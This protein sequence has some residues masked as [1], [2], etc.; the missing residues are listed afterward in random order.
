MKRQV[1]IYL[2]FIS[3]ILILFIS[4]KFYKH[5]SDYIRILKIELLGDVA[6]NRSL[7]ELKVNF[8]PQLLLNFKKNN[9]IC[10]FTPTW[11]FRPSHAVPTYPIPVVGDVDKN[12]NPEIYIGSYSKE[13]TALDGRSHN[14]LWQWKLPFG[15]I[16]GR[17]M[18]LSDLDGDGHEELLV[19]S[20]TTLPIR[21][22]ALNTLPKINSE[23]RL[24]W[25]VN[26]EGDFLE[27]GLNIYEDIHKN[28]KFIVTSTRDAPYSRGT[29][30]VIDENGELVIH[31]ILG[32]DNCVSRPP[33]GNIGSLKEP[34][35][36]NGSHN[37]YT[38]KWGHQ[39][40]ARN[41]FT[42][43][44]IWKTKK[45]GD[46]GYF[47]H[48][49]VDLNFDGK[50]EVLIIFSDSTKMLNYWIL[51][52]NTGEKIKKINWQLQGIMKDSK[53]LL[54]ATKD[55]TFCIDNS[56]KVLFGIKKIDFGFEEKLSGKLLLFNL[57]NTKD[58]IYLSVFDGLTG[59]LLQTLSSKYSLPNHNKISDYG[60]FGKPSDVVSFLTLADTDNNGFWDIL[61]QIKDFVVNLSL[62]Y[63][64][65][66]GVNPY[67]PYPFRNIDNGGVIYR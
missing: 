23:K 37:F 24:L 64:V 56:N 26:S 12:G 1:K 21:L 27:G 11:A 30:Q 51:D 6:L 19:G 36:I 43:Q 55:S 7:K 29:I 63:E 13:V 20:H 60:I 42:G 25:K 53:Q 57:K 9:T 10:Q 52:G 40:T 61:V 49:I 47:N 3:L 46:G 65:N 66:K 62:P 50:N 54:V 16:G 44:L 8:V 67:A 15:V 33:I 35:I 39:F 32:V 22:Y 58:S 45:I 28:K 38:P 5:S 2:I 59:K 41:L 31:P 34:V 17:A 4:Y 14:I 18:L 48:Q